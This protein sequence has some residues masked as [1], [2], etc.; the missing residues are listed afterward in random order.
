MDNATKRQEI[1]TLTERNLLLAKE[2][3]EFQSG[4]LS[5]PLGKEIKDRRAEMLRN[6]ERKEELKGKL[7]PQED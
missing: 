5:D 6:E 7:Q 4:K 3:E 1:T 2:I